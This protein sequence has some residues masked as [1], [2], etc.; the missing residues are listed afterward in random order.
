M[1]WWLKLGW[2]LRPILKQAEKLDMKLSVNSIIQ[3]LAVIGQA[4]AQASDVLPGKGKVWASVTLAAVQG[5]IAI[6]A[7]FR[8][9]DG[10]PATEPYRPPIQH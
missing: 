6:L 9:P 3:L 8:N 2:K 7:H 5:A 4:A 1:W 10:S